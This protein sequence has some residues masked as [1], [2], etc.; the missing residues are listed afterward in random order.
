ME[1]YLKIELLI[2]KHPLFLSV[3]ASL[4]MMKSH[5]SVSSEAHLHFMGVTDLN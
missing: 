4:K 5:L 3:C 1:T 2:L